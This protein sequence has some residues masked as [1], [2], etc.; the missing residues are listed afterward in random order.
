MEGVLHDTSNIDDREVGDT[1]PLRHGDL[2]FFQ[3]QAINADVDCSGRP[4]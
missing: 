2:D 1:M 3:D 4:P